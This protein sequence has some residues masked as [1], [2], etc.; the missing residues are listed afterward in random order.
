MH[1][2]EKGLGNHL[3]FLSHL[4]QEKADWEVMAGADGEEP[5]WEPRL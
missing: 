3:I 2:T 5:E 1:G 4:A